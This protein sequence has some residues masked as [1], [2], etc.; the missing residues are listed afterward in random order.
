MSKSSILEDKQFWRVINYITQV[1][2]PQKC[3][4]ICSFLGISQFELENYLAFL[5]SVNFDFSLTGKMGNKVYSPGENH[6]KFELQLTHLEWLQLQS[7]F[8]QFMEKHYC[9]ELKQTLANYEEKYAETDLH[10]PSLTLDMIF[11]T[12]RSETNLA[13][14]TNEQSREVILS[15]LNKSILEKFVIT[16]S[17]HGRLLDLYPRRI[18]KLDEDLSLIAEDVSDK[19]LVNILLPHISFVEESSHDYES[20]FSKFQ[21]SEF[22]Q[23]LKEMD[24]DWIRIVLKIYS[25]QDFSLQF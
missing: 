14:A 21:I 25:K 13:L 19:S 5:D 20:N 16:V 22:A 10:R 18:M 2:S 24:E 9:E 11:E 23:S 15:L 6:K 8:P 17:V 4:H 1:S 12:Y 3:D 7:F